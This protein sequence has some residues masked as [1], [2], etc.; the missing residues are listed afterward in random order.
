MFERGV[1]VES[2]AFVFLQIGSLTIKDFGDQFENLYKVFLR[3]LQPILPQHTNIADAYEKGTDEDQ[4]FV[5]N[6]AL[7]FTGFFHVS[8]H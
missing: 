4:Q 5:Q 8:H 3:Q 6:L 1:Q 7:F 2:S